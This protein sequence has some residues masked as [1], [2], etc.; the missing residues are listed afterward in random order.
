MET[1]SFGLLA[2]I[3]YADRPMRMGRYYRNALGKTRQCMDAFNGVPVD[4]CVHL[5]DLIDWPGQPDKGREALAAIMPVLRQFHGPM[6]H[7]LGNHDVD[8]V[9][10]SELVA[11][12]EMP[13][14][15]SWYSFDHKGVHFVALDCNFT[16]E[17][18]P[19]RWGV[20]RWDDCY[21]PQSQL[22]WLE[23]DLAA[24]QPD[25]VVLMVH[26]LL[27]DMEDPHVIRNASEVRRILETCNKRV[28][29]LQGHMHTGHK[30][31]KNGIGYHT[32]RSVVDGRTRTSFWVVEVN[33][34]GMTAAVYEST[35]NHGRPT[36][37]VL[38]EL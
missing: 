21:V 18:M 36:R 15:Q 31:V 14:G 7:L 3:Q 11:L 4:F 25:I 12:W 16:A 17:G 5:G 37:R 13:G 20:G 28:V 22:R 26:A 23:A 19:H 2:D 33:P 30:S 24:A 38:L 29:V 35:R 8:S 1:F 32:L 9:P 27:D 10:R 6:Y 34:G